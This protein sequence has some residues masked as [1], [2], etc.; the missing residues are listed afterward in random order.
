MATPN[1]VPRADGEGSLGRDGREWGL[2]RAKLIES[3]VFRLLI[4]TAEQLTSA[5]QDSRSLYIKETSSGTQLYNGDKLVA[6]QDQ[7]DDLRAIVDAFFGNN[8]DTGVSTQLNYIVENKDTLLELIDEINNLATAADLNALT[9]RVDALE[10]TAA[11]LNA[12]VS[13]LLVTASSLNTAVSTNASNISSNESKLL[14]KQE[15]LSATNRLDVDFL[16][17]VGAS[18]GNALVYDGTQWAPGNV[19]TV[20]SLDDLTDVNIGTASLNANDALLYDA[21]SQKFVPGQ[22]VTSSSLGAL[23]DVD[24]SSGVSNQQVLA[25]DGNAQKWE[26]QT[27]S[28]IV[29]TYGDS[30]VKSFLDGSLNGN[31]IPTSN[32][33]YDLGSAENKFRDLYLG[34]NSLHIDDVVV[35]ATLGGLAIRVGDTGSTNAIA[36]QPYVATQ[37][38]SIDA[39]T[40]A[41]FNALST[42]LSSAESDITA[43]QGSLSAAEGNITTLTSSVSSLTI[44]LAAATLGLSNAQ[45]D[46]TAL[47]TNLASAT[48]SIATNSG[49]I[50]S[51]NASLS[52]FTTEL[53][54]A[55]SSI[56]TL[57]GGLT[58][59]TGN[60][61]TNTSSISSLTTD[62]NSA[63]NDIVGL[64]TNLAAA[65]LA[66]AGLQ[67][68]LTTAQNDISSLETS[69]AAAT[70]NIAT[71]ESNIS[72]LTSYS[73]NSSANYISNATGLQDADTKLDSAIKSNYDSLQT[74]DANV[75]ALT[76]GSIG[77]TALLQDE[78]NRI[79]SA[80]GLAA[81]GSFN[82][83]N[84]TNYLDNATSFHDASE[85]LDAAIGVVAGTLGNY[86]TSTA[87][88]NGLAAKQNTLTAGSNIVLSGAT[89]STASTI[90]AAFQG[91]LTGNVTGNV[92][93][94]AG[95]VLAL[96][97][98]DTDNLAEGS[99]NQYFTDA[100]AQ[101]AISAVTNGGLT[102]SNGAF[103]LDLVTG[104]TLTSNTQAVSAL[105]AA[106]YADAKVAALVDSAPGTLDTLNE[107]AAALGDDPNFATTVT[108]SI[109]TKA[110]TTRTISAGTGLTGGGD[111]SANRTLSIGDT[112]VAA[113]TYGSAA[114]IPQLVVNAQG[115]ITGAS[116][117]ALSIASFDTGD[118]AEG[119][120]LYH[121]DA[122]ARAAVSVTDN[123]GDGS[124][125]YD[126]ST[127]VLAYTGPSAAETRAHFSAGGNITITGGTIAADLSSY[128]TAASINTSLADKQDTLSAG[129]GVSI[130][131]N[132][133]AISLGSF[134]TDDL[135]EGTANLY[136]T[137]ARARGA[138]SVNDAGG[139][140]SLA[141]NS[142]TGAITYTGPSAAEARAHFSAGSNVAITDGEISV[143]L[144][145]YVTA[146][147]LTTN[148]S[149]TS[150]INTSL[151][152][153]QD[154]LSAGTGIDITASTISVDATSDEISEGS[155][156]LYH[157]AARARSSISVAGDLAYNSSTGEISYTASSSSWTETANIISPAGTD[158]LLKIYGHLTEV[159]DMG[160]YSADP[161]DFTLNAGNNLTD[162]VDRVVDC[163]NLDSRRLF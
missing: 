154:T 110:P 61:A 151:A 68:S 23:S 4:P 128:L 48:L 54:D 153:K 136:H 87:L 160:E 94:S 156:N 93:G 102:Y 83:F 70:G 71:I 12:D 6:T 73:A 16:S 8:T 47:E 90:S 39:V 137:D 145:D 15:E 82:S 25:Y 57:Q 109:A 29:S 67:T 158:D 64:T 5:E 34:S 33:A 80:V 147:S 127:G 3:P 88:T 85:K 125:S 134:D 52:T 138:I 40:S 97:G 77:P 2:V 104:S 161:V 89:I 162:T 66:T 78:I 141:Y 100:R 95:T 107:L 14:S 45:A 111:L 11:S 13:G 142:T 139:D 155:T 112:G 43:L 81:S 74:L 122:R 27:L 101:S 58:A 32:D 132:T 117:S 1:I 115:Q 26:A 35:S 51:I 38:S 143:N 20:G 53:S 44:D 105:A 63:Q 60:I 103:A 28:S 121:T 24:L 50:T 18:T 31:I 98:L 129:T 36:T 116:T 163:G 75:Q 22:V 55:Q 41:S 19:S 135:S 149:T 126:N 131:D 9:T 30:D 150:S 114:F 91:N 124:L 119:S 92:S 120:N 49:R 99:T 37:I 108:N 17:H 42:Q 65:T 148:Y 72:V 62:L 106:N 69:L 146:S 157:T 59:A 113:G 84:G 159:F 86:A 76:A 7:V 21:A 140:G 56:T 152:T 130:A 118:L 96:T 10:V 133:V 46:I 79:E 144:S 123:G